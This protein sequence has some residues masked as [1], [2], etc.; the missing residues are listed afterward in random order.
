MTKLTAFLGNFGSRYE[1]TRH[2]IAWL[3]ASSLPFFSELQF[4]EKF[5]GEFAA[6]EPQSLARLLLKS[7][8]IPAHPPANPL[9]NSLLR[10]AEKSRPDTKAAASEKLYFLKPR[11]FMNLS[12]ESI[13]ELAHFYKIAPSNIIVVH[14]E[15]ELP[16]ATISLKLGGGLGG[17]N[18]LRSTTSCLQSSDFCRIRLGIGKPDNTNIADYVLSPFTDTESAALPEIFNEAA[19]LLIQL[20]FSTSPA[21]LLSTWRKRKINLTRHD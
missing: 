19:Q 14:D 7:E 20:L 5:K 11:T 21:E 12:G 15:L 10:Q 16:F 8:K 3:F 13:G 17:H 9:I 18:G 4:R 1:R 6:I 2:N